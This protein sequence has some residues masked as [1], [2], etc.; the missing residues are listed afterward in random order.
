LTYIELQSS[1]RDMSR[2]TKQ[3]GPRMTLQTLAIL[4]AMLEAPTAPHYGLELAEG[5]NFPTGTVYPILARLES[6]GWVSSTWENVS[7]A[8]EGRPRR[9]LYTLTG[10]GARAARAALDN[11]LRLIGPAGRATPGKS[12]HPGESTA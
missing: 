12:L 1:L 8:Q 11:G 5:I 3:T 7:P 4:Q 2:S 10:S 6:A 9:R